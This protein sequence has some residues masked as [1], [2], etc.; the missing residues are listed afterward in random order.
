[1]EPSASNQS[2]PTPLRSV[3]VPEDCFGFAA[4]PLNRKIDTW[5]PNAMIFMWPVAEGA[6]IE[7]AQ[8]EDVNFEGCWD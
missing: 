5:E 1:M 4:R 6:L 8:I 3:E 2:C 7:G